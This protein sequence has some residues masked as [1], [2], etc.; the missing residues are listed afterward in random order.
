MSLP[1]K[2]LEAVLA[3]LRANRKTLVD[4]LTELDHAIEVLEKLYTHPL[5]KL[6]A[7][8]K[9]APTLRTVTVEE[10]PRNLEEVEEIV[11]EEAAPVA[12]SP[13][14]VPLPYEERIPAV[15]NHRGDLGA[16]TAADLSIAETVRKAVAEGRYDQTRLSRR[17]VELRPATSLVSAQQAV[18][19]LLSRRELKKGDDLLIR[20]VKDGRV[21][22]LPPL[23]SEER[24]SASRYPQ[25][26]SR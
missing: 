9:R 1:T 17:V 8:P 5:E 21:M 4:N 12:E 6:T 16:T 26:E 22:D 2:H 3:D 24:L 10:I 25:Y 23:T 11:L 18:Y 13:T 14:L 20:L 19:T 15:I 7:L